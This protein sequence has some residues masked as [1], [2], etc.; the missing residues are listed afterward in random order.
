MVPTMNKIVIIMSKAAIILFAVLAISGCRENN[1]AQI[2]DVVR[3]ET[4][5]LNNEDLDA[6][7]TFIDP[8]LE[9]FEKTKNATSMLF[10]NYD[11]HYTLSNLVAESVSD[12]EALVR[13]TQ[14]TEKTAGPDFRN[15]RIE[16]VHTLRKRDGGWKIS[17]TKIN[18]IDYLDD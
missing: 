6:S 5:A 18:K 7:M 9:S 8:Q 4:D 15:N 3:A 1:E 13:F 2:L 14:V 16:G 10:E 17:T 11:L 12:D